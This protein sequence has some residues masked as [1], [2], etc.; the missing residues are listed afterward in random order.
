[1]GGRPPQPDLAGGGRCPETHDTNNGYA[2]AYNYASGYLYNSHHVTDLFQ[3]H[4]ESV[5]LG[6]DPLPVDAPRPDDVI[7]LEDDESVGKVA[8][9]MTDVRRHTHRVHPVAIH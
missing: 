4:P 2:T 3:H 5:E 7:E 1:V 9:Q 6:D 8:V